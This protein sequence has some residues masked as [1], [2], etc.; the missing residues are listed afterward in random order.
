MKEQY[1]A[2][3]RVLER[4][5]YSKHQWVICVDLKMVNFLLGQQSGYTKHPCFLCK[6]DSRAKDEHYIKRDWGGRELKVG[7]KNVINEVLAPAFIKRHILCT[8][9]NSPFISSAMI[10]VLAFLTGHLTARSFCKT[11]PLAKNI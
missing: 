7:E 9:T 1:D 11:L 5:N 10:N 3:K 8:S 2:I 4:I 6:W